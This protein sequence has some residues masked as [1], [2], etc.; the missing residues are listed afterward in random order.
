[1]KKVSGGN[2]GFIQ[3]MINTFIDAM[4]KAI[5][6]IRGNITS[7]HWGELAK[8]VHKIK[9][10]LTMMGLRRLV[11][12]GLLSKSRPKKKRRWMCFLR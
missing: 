10:S 3:D 8:S 7:E 11:R 2:E 4:P 1:M 12:P 6:E 9:P 5:A